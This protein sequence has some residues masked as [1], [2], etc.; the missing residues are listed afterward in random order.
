MPLTD[1]AALG[2]AL[3][4]AG[5]RHELISYGGAPHAF[6]VF[7]SERYREDADRKSWARFLAFLREQLGRGRQRRPLTLSPVLPSA[8][9]DGKIDALRNAVRQIGVLDHSGDVSP[10]EH[11]IGRRRSTYRAPGSG[12][13]ARAG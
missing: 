12:R 9:A 7:G 8:K 11:S 10:K 3:E 5:I 2:V 1:L 4:K 13:F 6:S